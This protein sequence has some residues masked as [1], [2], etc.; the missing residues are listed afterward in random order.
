[1]K[2]TVTNDTISL[3]ERPVAALVT[4]SNWTQFQVR[5]ARREWTLVGELPEGLHR[6]ASEAIT[7][8]AGVPS[9]LALAT[10]IE[11]LCAERGVNLEENP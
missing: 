10:R 7:G 2:F 11:V 9:A 4:R 1:M 3:G 6:A 5:N 8:M